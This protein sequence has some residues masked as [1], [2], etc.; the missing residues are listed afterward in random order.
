[1]RPVH[2]SFFTPTH[3]ALHHALV[4]LVQEL[5]KVSAKKVF[6]QARLF[7]DLQP[8]F[9]RDNVVALNEG[10]DLFR[11]IGESLWLGETFGRQRKFEHFQ[12]IID[13]PL[14]ERSVVIDVETLKDCI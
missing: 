9:L 12:H 10:R 3:S 2:N 4:I 7:P 14:I 5:H 8:L 6:Q 11:S 1:M 13:L